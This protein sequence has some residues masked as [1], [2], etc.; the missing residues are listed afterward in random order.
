MESRAFIFKR[1]QNR[2]VIRTERENGTLIFLERM[3][4]IKCAFD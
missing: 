3:N 1:L 4:A 2:S